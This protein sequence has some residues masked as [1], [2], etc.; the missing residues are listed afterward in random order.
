MRCVLPLLLLVV[1][2]IRC[3]L[4]GQT[5]PASLPAA[6]AV[7]RSWSVD[8]ILPVEKR[9]DAAGRNRVA[10]LLARTRLDFQVAEATPRELCRHL[11]ALTGDRVNFLHPNRPD[12]APVPPIDLQL[13]ATNLLSVL[14]ALQMVS[15]LQ[16]VYRDGVV[17]LVP[18]ADFKPMTFLQVVDLRGATAPLRSF[19]GPKLGL[20]GPGGESGVLFPPEEESGTTVSGFTAE[21]LERLIRENVTPEAWGDV[22]S[23]TSHGGLFTIRHT[24]AGHRAVR[25]LLDELGVL[26]VPR[27]LVLPRSPGRIGR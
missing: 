6:A 7:A 23:L 16:F 25:R 8:D 26:P 22:A 9:S 21:G 12:A 20:Q 1:A 14:A 11:S 19:P 5:G 15:G 17:F 18:R 2:A 3:P 4:P 27:T 13:R 10:A 24:E